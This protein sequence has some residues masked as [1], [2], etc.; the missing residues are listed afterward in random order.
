MAI[1]ECVIHSCVSK[2]GRVGTLAAAKIRFRRTAPSA[3]VSDCMTLIEP[4]QGE[5]KLDLYIN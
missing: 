3:Y 1:Q 5:G 2:A 4:L